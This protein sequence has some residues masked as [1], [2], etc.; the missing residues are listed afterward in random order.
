[1][2]GWGVETS[3]PRTR[4]LLFKRAREIAAPRVLE[5]EVTTATICSSVSLEEMRGEEEKRKTFA[6]EV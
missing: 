4:A 1:V 2:E 5:D 3:M 6:D